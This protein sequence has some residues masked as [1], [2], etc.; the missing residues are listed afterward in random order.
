M[1]GRARGGRKLKNKK[2]GRRKEK[3]E[4]GEAEERC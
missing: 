4:K 1:N 2:V 3:G